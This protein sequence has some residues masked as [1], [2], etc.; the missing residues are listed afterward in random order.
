MGRN[1]EEIISRIWSEE[2]DNKKREILRGFW[3]KAE[4]LKRRREG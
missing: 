2:L 1:K 3:K 4:A